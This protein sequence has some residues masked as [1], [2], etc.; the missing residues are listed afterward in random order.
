MRYI[1]LKSSLLP[2]HTCVTDADWIATSSMRWTHRL[3]RTQITEEI[4]E[5]CS[6]VQREYRDITREIES[7]N[8]TFNGHI[9]R[10]Q[11]TEETRVDEVIEQTKSCNVNT[12]CQLHTTTV[13]MSTR[14]VNYTQNNSLEVSHVVHGAAAAVSTYWHLYSLTQKH[15]TVFSTHQ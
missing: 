2:T 9:V 11:N 14:P 8:S 15:M 3:A 6:D 7:L 4:G 12:S 13:A 5:N 1:V 10:L